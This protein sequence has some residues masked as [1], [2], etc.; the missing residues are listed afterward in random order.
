ML[1]TS[2]PLAGGRKAVLLGIRHLG[3]GAWIRHLD[4]ALGIR[5]LD[6]ALW[7]PVL[8]SGTWDP[9]LGSGAWDPVLGMN[10]WH[11]TRCGAESRWHQ[12]T[13]QTTLRRLRLTPHTAP[14]M[15]TRQAP[16][17]ITKRSR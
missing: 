13:P 8:G 4:P 11:S 5:C 12:I 16:P 10:A 9:V 15:M 7:D 14:T 6:L 3:S 2:R 1:P 17:H